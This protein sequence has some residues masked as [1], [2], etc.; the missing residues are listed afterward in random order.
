MT[1]N[2]N[3]E[4][5]MYKQGSSVYIGYTP[6]TVHDQRGRKY[7]N[8]KGRQVNLNDIPVLPKEAKPDPVFDYIFNG[9]FA[10]HPCHAMD[11]WILRHR[12]KQNIRPHQYKLKY[13]N[14][15]KP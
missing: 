5:R 6:I 11:Y 3:L 15:A 2:I 7:V 14:S 9:Q 12:L 13:I 8:Y 4:G 10:T 1:H